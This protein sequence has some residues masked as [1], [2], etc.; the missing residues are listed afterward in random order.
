MYFDSKSKAVLPLSEIF[1]VSKI[2]LAAFICLER[3]DVNIGWKRP[4][5]DPVRLK[6]VKTR[7]DFIFAG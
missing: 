1:Y 3:K 2:Y 6:S 7:R 4:R 5:D